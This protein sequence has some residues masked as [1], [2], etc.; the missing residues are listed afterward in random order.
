MDIFSDKVFRRVAQLASPYD[1]GSQAHSQE[2]VEEFLVREK[3]E[4][5]NRIVGAVTEILHGFDPDMRYI[6][7]GYDEMIYEELR[8][9]P[10]IHV[11][12]DVVQL[13]LQELGRLGQVINSGEF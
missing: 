4:L 9:D 7:S 13:V 5:F 1:I 3:E 2:E 6:P 12:Y 11:Y 10:R 8:E